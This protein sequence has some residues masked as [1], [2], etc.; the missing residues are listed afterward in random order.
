[1]GRAYQELGHLNR[2]MG[3][4]EKAVMHYRQA[5]ELNPA[6]PCILEF[7]L[8]ILPKNENKPAA[9]HA[10]EQ[11]KKLQITSW[12]TFIYRADS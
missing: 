8:S 9:D 2:D 4:E 6:L 11:I 12:I 5:C 3:N 7:S 1:M 10:L